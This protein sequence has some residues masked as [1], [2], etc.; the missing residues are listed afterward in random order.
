MQVLGEPV[1][2][3]VIVALF[4]GEDVLGEFG[5]GGAIEGTYENADPIEMDGIKEQGRS[6]GG[7][8]PR[9]DTSAGYL[10]P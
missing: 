10:R 8:F 4:G 5:V 2:D 9:I 1:G 3:V 6:R 7:F